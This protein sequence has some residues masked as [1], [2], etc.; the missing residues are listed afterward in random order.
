MRE[1]ILVGADPRAAL[2]IVRA[3]RD[4]SESELRGFVLASWRIIPRLVLGSSHRATRRRRRS[5]SAKR[6]KPSSARKGSPPK[7]V[8]LPP[9][10][11]EWINPKSHRRPLW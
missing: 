2:V 11:Y 7:R 1:T 3:L 6:A 8:K 5:E 10:V 9:V 4:L